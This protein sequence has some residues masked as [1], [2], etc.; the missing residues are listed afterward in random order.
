MVNSVTGSTPTVKSS[1]FYVNDIHG[2]LPKMEQLT[3]ASAQFDS[4][5]KEK[6]VDAL[7]LC[8]GDTFIGGDEKINTAAATFLDTAGIQ[9]STYGNHEF[10]VSAPKLANIIKN[11]KT[12]FLGMNMNI[13]DKNALKQKTLRSTV[14]EQ[15]GNKYGVIGLQPLDLYTRIK[16]KELLDGITVDDEPQTFKELQE[17]VNGLKQQGINKIILLSHTGNKEEK[18]IAQSIDGIDVI[19]GGHSHDMIEGIKQGENLFYSPSGEPVIITQAGRDGHNFGILNVEY[20]A[21]GK[22]VKAQNNVEKTSA[23][24]KNLLMSA[25]ADKILGPSPV[26]GTLS[27]CDPYP[28]KPLIEENPFASFVADAV[29]KEMGADIVL[30]NSA[31][32]RGNVSSGEITERDI[33]SAFP[34]K[35]KLC[36]VELSEKDLID[37]LNHGG[38][39]LKTPD[40]KP[41]IM[42]VSGMTYTLDKEGKV[43]EAS[44]LDKN[45]QPQKIDVNN[46]NPNKKYIAIYD[47]Y[48]CNGG[49][50]FDM[51]KK[52]D[53]PA[54]LEKYDYDKDKVAVDYIKKL[55]GQPF[56]IV[57]DGRIKFL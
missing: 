52:I 31:N 7:K 42:Q 37:A 2:Q 54:L 35:N 48:V 51:L 16:K 4:F 45:N 33:S 6:K 32:F 41:N 40:N 1:I 43:V 57:K 23:Y 55:N 8:S 24:G 38:T 39:S 5:A 3:N 28:K 10:D 47:D 21:Q 44:I 53:T 17:E 46:P 9:A 15:N 30:V 34:F 19:L 11:V 26:I 50:K 22:I 27:K 36:K 13:P 29:R 56:E 20:D 25:T 12:T 18:K 14:I 49:D